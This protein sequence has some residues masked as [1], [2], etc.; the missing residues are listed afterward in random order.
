M[1]GLETIM[2]MNKEAGDR[3]REL[4]VQP[5]MLDDKAQLDEMPP[6]PFPNIGDDAVEVDKLYERVDTLFCDSSGFGAPGEPA[7]TI[8]QLMAKLGD[9]IEEHGEIRVA[10]ESEGQFQIYLGVWK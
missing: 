4:D 9:L 5:F 3:A 1:Y 10:I 2:E 8:D 6:F 7:L